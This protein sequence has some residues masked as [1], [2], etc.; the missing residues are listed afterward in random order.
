MVHSFK[1]IRVSRKKY[2]KVTSGCLHS[3]IFNLSSRSRRFRSLNKEESANE[4]QQK[5]K[6]TGWQFRFHPTQKHT[7]FFFGF[8]RKL[9]W[10]PSHLFHS[11]QSIC[12]KG[13]RNQVTSS[14]GNKVAFFLPGSWQPFKNLI[15][16]GCKK[17]G[18][19]ISL[20][21]RYCTTSYKP[22]NTL[23]QTQ[24]S[25]TTETRFHFKLVNL[26][27]FQSSSQT[28]PIKPDWITCALYTLQ[29]P[30]NWIIAPTLPVRILRL[31]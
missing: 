23:G 26:G 31:W 13:I 9:T 28:S 17:S 27:L 22:A 25:P 18:I 12:S 10:A 11:S 20:Y 8:V 14:K 16:P 19:S 30:C 2:C 4:K 29:P 24:L 1:F 21:A 6:S 3:T 7:D 15:G 5:C